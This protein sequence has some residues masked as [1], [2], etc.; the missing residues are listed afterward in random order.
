VLF[1]LDDTLLDHRGAV[2]VAIVGHLRALGHPY[3]VADPA[4]EVAAWRDLE[5]THY[6]RYLAGEIGFED[7]RRVRAQEL[8]ARHGVQ[9]TS[10]EAGRWF[11]D[12]FE[13]YVAQWR[14]H[15]DALPCLDALRAAV[16]GI[17]FGMITNG[18]LDFQ[19]RKIDAT[20]LRRELDVIVAS[21]DVGVT[22]PD[23][24][25]FALA[26]ERLGVHPDQAAYV[27]DRLGT[28]AIGAARAGLTG[29]WIDRVEASVSERERAE[30]EELGVR[31]ITTLADLP[32]TLL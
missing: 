23:A 9:L 15:D 19:L 1:D 22:K 8:A 10:A 32:A 7:N 17:R 18:E 6:H 27:G 11:A 13:R 3:E 4:A 29:V 20:G 21:G 2:G 24:R 26:C 25:I 28:D 16:P 5:E 14:L 12:Y 30:A 31:R